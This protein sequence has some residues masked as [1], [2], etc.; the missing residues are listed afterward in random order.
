MVPGRDARI[1]ELLPVKWIAVGDGARF[2]G[3]MT[4]TWSG[5][6]GEL[7]VRTQRCC[8]CGF[9]V[10]LAITVCLQ[11]F[12]FAQ[13]AKE[14][15]H[16]W[17]KQ[18][19][20]YARIMS[21]VK[22]TPVADTMPTRGGKYFKKGTEYTGVPYSSVKAVGRC[23][24]FDIYLKTFLAAVENPQSVLYTEN[25]SG[26][27]SNAAPYY[28]KVCS[29][30]TSYALQCALPYRSSHHG[31]EL[32]KGVV[33]VDPQS[34][35]AAQPGDVI[36]TP[37][38]KV[39]GGSHV[40]LVTGVERSG[41]RVT[42]VRVEDSWP[43]TTRNLLRKA[44]DFNSHISSRN[45]KLYRITDF[46]AWHGHNKAQSFRFPSYDEDSATPAI[47]RVL[48]LDRGDWVPY[49]KEQA[50]KLNVM[51]RDSKGVKTLVVKHGDTVI[52]Q[53][54][55][56][57][58]GVVERSFS[59]CGD[60]TAHCVMSDGSLS[61]PCEFAVCDLDFSLPSEPFVQSKSWEVKF[62]A[63]NLTVITLQLF[64]RKPPYARHCVWLTE[65]DRRSGRVAV[66]AGLIRETGPLRVWLIG[67]NK[68][69][70]LT[71]ELRTTG[72]RKGGEVE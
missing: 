50:V 52:E 3:R 65:Q 12:S 16:A 19:V 68:Y 32:R 55:L 31:P 54:P 5:S 57:G 59:V 72:Q 40:E 63:C 66:P 13:A 47:N 18:A 45:R 37:P 51:D 22:W 43:P 10:S 39:G 38:A 29:T 24:G 7:L 20:E 26:K 36:Y 8:F 9:V 46:D 1:L 62:T 71:R 41:K 70:R 17:Q 30:F 25:L 28:G 23:I 4:S 11:D 6:K 34:A 69:G 67:E 44:K 27:V 49:Y 35:Q 58:R 56:R 48:L 33:L 61:Q 15:P 42:A 21:R 53:I 64:S 60:Y 2:N 14:G